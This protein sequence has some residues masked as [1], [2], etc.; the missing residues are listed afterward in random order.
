MTQKQKMQMKI[1]EDVF[2]VGLGNWGTALANHLAR[3]GCSVT[4]WSLDSEI[5]QSLNATQRNPKFLT[6]ITLSTNLK[7]TEELGL[8]RE[9][10]KVLL[11]LP[12]SALHSV[13]PQIE[14]Q[15]GTSII[16]AIKGIDKKTLLTPLSLSREFYGDTCSYVVLSGP[17]FAADVAIGKPAGVVAGSEDIEIAQ[18]VAQLFSNE[19]LRVYTSTDPLG[20]ELGGIVKNIIALAV[21][22]CDGLELGDS[23]RAG[24]VTRG[25]AEMMRFAESFGAEPKTLI[26]LSGLGDLI[27]TTTS[28]KSRNRTVGLRLGKGEDIDSIVETLGSVA[29]GVTVTALIVK[30]ARKH[31]I[32]MP[33]TEAVSQ[34]IEG[35][36]QSRDMASQLINRPLRAE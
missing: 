20:V 34:V 21:G 4:G 25:L 32:E 30:L 36:I 35:K 19:S 24:L 15:S 12:S 7:A 1:N 9:F 27:V 5:V 3:K 23:A 10:K 2:V 6:D 22:I 11:V 26:G 18:E 16:S 13:L 17:S 8:V 31:N 28:N 29:E 14:V 33:I